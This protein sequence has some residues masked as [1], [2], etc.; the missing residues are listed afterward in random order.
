ME[1]SG[2]EL[3]MA[4]VLY[5]L[6]EGCEARFDI[7]DLSMGEGSGDVTELLESRHIVETA[8]QLI[9]QGFRVTENGVR[10]RAVFC[11]FYILLHSANQYAT[12]YTRE[13]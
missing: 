3:L 8:L 13:L 2:K 1:Y 6:Q 9:A 7:L 12:R 10:R 4:G 5:P 11:D